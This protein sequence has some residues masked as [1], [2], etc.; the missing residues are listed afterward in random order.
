MVQL[1]KCTTLNNIRIHFIIHHYKFSA[2]VL[3]ID[4]TKIPGAL[5]LRGCSSSIS[6]LF[7]IELLVNYR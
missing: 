1:L 5:N 6:I 2:I 4:L 3:G 7:E